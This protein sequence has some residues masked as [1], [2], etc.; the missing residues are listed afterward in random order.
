MRES[1]IVDFPAYK[2]REDGTVF[3]RFK[4]KTSIITDD[5][6]E[7]R[8]VICSSTGYPLVTLC[9]GDGVRKNKTIHRLLMEAFVPNPDNLPHVNHIDGDKLNYSLA[10]LEWCTPAHNAEHAARIGLCD[11]RTKA[12]EVAVIQ[13]TKEGD[14]VAEHS[15]LHE[16]G[17]QT[18]IAW[19]NIWKVCNFRRKTAGGFSWEYK[20]EN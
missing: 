2:I 1:I 19:Q 5:W 9:S 4:E 11:E 14:F 8:R 20:S 7:I 15:S 16:A 10:N 6:R 17:R 18:G 3:S 12:L 13:K